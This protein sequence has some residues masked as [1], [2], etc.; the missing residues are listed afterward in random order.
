MTTSAAAAIAIVL[1]IYPN[2]LAWMATRRSWDQ[3]NAFTIGNLGLL[4]SLAAYTQSTGSWSLVVGTMQPGS[5]AVGAL[6]GLVPLAAILALTFAPGQLGRD[7]VA[8]GVGDVS[9]SGFVFRLGV[10]VALGTVLCEEF[11]F[12]GVLHTAL[13][14]AVQPGAAVGI[15]AVCY[16]LWHGVLQ[17]NTFAARSCRARYASAAGGTATYILLGLVLAAL[18]QATG[19]LAAPLVAHG[20]LDMGMFAGMYARRRQHAKC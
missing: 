17:I 20:V 18:R 12:R 5:I 7:I 4:I 13:S 2:S 8:A 6:V 11:A 3:W 9:L 1:V 15:G 19:S 14:S 10:Q 16:G